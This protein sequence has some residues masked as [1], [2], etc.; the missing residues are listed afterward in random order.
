MIHAPF[1]ANA[2]SP[3]R[4]RGRVRHLSIGRR[5]SHRETGIAL[6][7][8]LLVDERARWTRPGG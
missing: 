2:A 3:S 5:G 6:K 4:S 8:E 1:S 7:S